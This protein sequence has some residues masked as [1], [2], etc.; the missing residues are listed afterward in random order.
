[1]ED[2]LQLGNGSYLLL[3]D[4]SFLLLGSSPA[5][6][7]PT[8]S[9][10]PPTNPSI[11]GEAF[12]PITTWVA[13]A[14]PSTT[15]AEDN[16]PT[17]LVTP[18]IPTTPPQIPVRRGISLSGLENPGQLPGTLGTSFFEST[19]NTYNYFAA[20]GFTTVRLAFLWER[21][22]PSLNGALDSSYKA[23]LD[24]QIAKAKSA[25]LKVILDCHN[26]GRRIVSPLSGGITDNFTGAVSQ[27]NYPYAD[28]SQNGFIVLRDYGESLL[29][30][31]INPVSPA[32][33]Y[34]VSFNMKFNSRDTSF[35]GEGLYVRPMWIDDN[36]CYEFAADVSSNSW[37]LNKIISGV[38]TQLATGS[39]TWGTVST[40]AVDIDVNQATNGKINVSLNGT[41]LFTTNSIASD[42]ALAHGQVAFFAAGVHVQIDTLVLNINGDT[43]TGNRGQVRIGDPQVSIDEFAQFWGLVAAAYANDTTVFAY[44]LMNEPHDMPVPST[45][46]NYNVNATVTLM[47]QAA[48]DAIRQQDITHGIF[49]EFDHWAGGQNF[50]SSYGTNPIPWLN[51][52]YNLITYSFHYY[53]DND[54]SGSYQQSFAES[55]N[56]AIGPDL[57]P[58]LAWAANN[59]VNLHC[60]EYGVPNTAE[61]QVCLTTFFTLMNQYKVW[62]NHWAAGDSYTSITTLQPTGSSPNYVD[63]LQMAIVG[64]TAN[65][66]G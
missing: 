44:D 64:A 6:V 23:I 54:H 39:Q 57:T 18:V 16:C 19:Q 9:P 25:G 5:P 21:L 60:G 4:G 22:Q 30:T 2:R 53:F 32:T 48:I 29:G 49:A 34:H 14:A 46:T 61:W 15:W 24:D 33:G 63:R 10:T 3:G 42:G 55:N 35:G 51:D 65:L 12:C 66:G 27:L 59:L 43:T 20:K 62:T 50:T 41:P 36:N 7:T 38:K 31:A 8:P 28:Y 37:T 52:P 56:T 17:P 58:M 45:P 26:Y 40:Y 11:I 1:M 47:Y 13:D